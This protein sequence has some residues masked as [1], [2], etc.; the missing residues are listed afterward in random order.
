MRGYT[1]HKNFL[2]NMMEKKTDECHAHFTRVR[3]AMIM[4]ANIKICYAIMKYVKKKRAEKEAEE[5]RKRIAREALAK[6]K[7]A[8]YQPRASVKQNNTKA[9]AVSAVPTKSTPSAA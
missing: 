4:D 2:W 5:E 6:K 8:K 1:S 7:K 3:K 9:N